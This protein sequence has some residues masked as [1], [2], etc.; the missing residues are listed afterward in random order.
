[1]VKKM[2]E[3]GDAGACH[4]E[5]TRLKNDRSPWKDSGIQKALL[6]GNWWAVLRR[7]LSGAGWARREI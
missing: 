3:P 1:M 7:G 2:Q 4:T 5:A 6:G